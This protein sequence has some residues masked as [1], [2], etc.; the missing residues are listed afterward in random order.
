MPI[1]QELHK[2]RSRRLNG[3]FVMSETKKK[4]KEQRFI[5]KEGENH[6]LSARRSVEAEKEFFAGQ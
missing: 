2:G 4:I 5:N 6:G 1:S 3:G